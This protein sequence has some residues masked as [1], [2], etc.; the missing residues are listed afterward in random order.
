[1]AQKMCVVG[2]VTIDD[3]VV[4][5]DQL[6]TGMPG[7]NAIYTALGARVW[8]QE[9]DITIAIVSIAGDDGGK[10]TDRLAELGLDVSGIRV[11]PGPSIRN[12]VLY[13]ESGQRQFV[14]QVP[15]ERRDLLC[16]D[17]GDLPQNVAAFDL[18][19]VAGLPPWHQERILRRLAE[20]QVTRQLDLGEV[21]A[22]AT[23]EALKHLNVFLPSFVEYRE[24][25][26]EG[27]SLEDGIRFLA[28]QGPDHVVLKLGD[29]G[30]LIYSKRHDTFASLPACDVLEVDA[31]GAGDAFCGGFAA[32]WLYTRDVVTAAAFGTVSAS[33][34]VEDY[35]LDG[36]V[37]ADARLAADRKNW[38]L[39][40]IGRNRMEGL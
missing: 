16:P 17:V 22:Q 37:N 14:L 9:A 24:L 34:A 7:G 30:A 39:D 2:N 27:L 12:W 28:G 20:T 6:R 25:V 8:A 21:H 31:T 11:E 5:P 38:L 23:F 33:F 1:M 29:Q 4:A 15:Q 19:H 32:G 13:T 36:L 40:A 18:V 26:D 3:V 10:Q 35:G